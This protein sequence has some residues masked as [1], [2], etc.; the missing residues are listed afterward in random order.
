M[1]SPRYRQAQFS[2]ITS[3]LA[4]QSKLFLSQGN[5][6]G[7]QLK[8]KIEYGVKNLPKAQYNFHKHSDGSL[9]EIPEYR[10]D[11]NDSSSSEE[12][13]SPN[14]SISLIGTLADTR[15]KW[16]ELLVEMDYFVDT[17]IS[18][19]SSLAKEDARRHIQPKVFKADFLFS[20]CGIVP[21]APLDDAEWLNINRTF[22]SASEHS[23]RI[24]DIQTIIR[25]AMVMS[26]SPTC[27]E[28]ESVECEEENLIVKKPD[29]ASYASDDSSRAITAL[30]VPMVIKPPK[31]LSEVI[32]Q[33]LGF[34]VSRL[35]AQLGLVDPLAAELHGYCLGFDGSKVVL[36]FAAVRNMNFHVYTSDI[37]GMLLWPFSEKPRST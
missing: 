33:S 1:T 23:T 16:T 12:D 15:I 10:A 27:V 8:R 30:M 20:L 21:A 7:P 31:R 3:I 9:V 22:P 36:G 28:F 5:T 13:N 29:G 6:I 14:I 25:Q 26:D 2:S 24:R 35:R 19:A 17:H 37:T 34:L 11:G 18:T 4:F 32:D